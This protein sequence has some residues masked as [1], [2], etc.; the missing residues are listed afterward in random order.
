MQDLNFLD[1]LNQLMLTIDADT[2]EL[3][4]KDSGVLATSYIGKVSN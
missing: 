1:H 2:G 4:I 3:D